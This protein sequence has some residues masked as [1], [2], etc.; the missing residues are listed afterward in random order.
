MKQLTRKVI[1]FDLDG[2][3]CDSLQLAVNKYNALAAQWK[4]KPV[5]D[6]QAIRHE[7]LQ[8][9]LAAHKL[10]KWKLPI[11]QY[12]LLKAMAAR[13]KD[14]SAF[15]GVREMLLELKERGYILGILTS[16]SRANTMQFLQAQ[17][18]QIFEFVYCGSSLF[19]KARLLKRIKSI[20][21]ATELYYV[22]DENRDIEAARA[23]QIPVI[24]VTWGY[25]AAD[26]LAQYNPDKII[27]T[28]K[29]LIAVFSG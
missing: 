22:G 23:A 11:I 17:N 26:L 14:L 4:L 18:L 7:S 3:L 19:G 20:V 1:V 12:R 6:L 16:N 2:T 15:P 9:V 27:N 24:A 10:S 29:E 8:K 28:P 13:F 21:K 25:Q 5:D